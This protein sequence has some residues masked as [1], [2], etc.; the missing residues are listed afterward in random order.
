[1]RASRGRVLVVTA[2][3]AALLVP[4]AT[5]GTGV[6]RVFATIVHVSS[7]VAP[8]TVDSTSAGTAYDGTAVWTPQMFNTGPADPSL[9]S[10]SLDQVGSQWAQ[11]IAPLPPFPISESSSS[12]PASTNF[13]FD[14]LF[15]DIQP[16]PL[17]FQFGFHTPVTTGFDTSRT[18]VAPA[19]DVV[20]SGGGTQA[21]QASLTLRDPSLAGAQIMIQFFNTFDASLVAGSVT[22]PVLDG[23]EFLEFSDTNGGLQWSA[24]NAVV[25]KTYTVQFQVAVTPSGA[26]HFRP[27]LSFEADPIIT[28][29]PVTATGTSVSLA[30]PLLGGTF[31]YTT[32]A[33]VDWV[34]SSSFTRRVSLS[35]LE[36]PVDT[37]PPAVVFNGNQGTY[38]I[39]D[40]VH[41]TCWTFDPF[42][43]SGIASDPCASF[44]I[45]G[46]AWTFGAGTH[47]LPA[48]GLVA[49]DNAG[50]QSAP[51]QTTF[52]VTVNASDLCVLTASFAGATRATP[53]CAVLRGARI[54]HGTIVA[55]DAIVQALARTRV[56]TAAQAATLEALATAL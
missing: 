34:G 54:T 46:A 18:L 45:D 28:A 26:E 43:S 16:V 53:A 20:P 38:G 27:N 41:I 30:D 23:G 1:M 19:T 52:T 22:T 42:P 2:A 6:A 17:G 29:Q 24:G 31:T 12:L 51:A 48:T 21:W 9:P 7:V 13:P 32:G 47:T 37:T 5:A 39:L 8:A 44:A 4:A 55:Y 10:I 3:L 50:N 36:S 33:P 35:Q 40:H 11:P 49:T 14:P 15:N 56:I 25:G